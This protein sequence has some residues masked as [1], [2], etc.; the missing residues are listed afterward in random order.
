MAIAIYSVRRMRPLR[1]R[2]SGLAATA[3]ASAGLLR[4]EL[5]RRRLARRYLR[6]SG[7]EV[8]ALHRPLRVS[9]GAKVRYVD[10][11]DTEG[12]RRHYPELEGKKLVEVD[13]ID[14][15]ERLSSQAD[16][17]VD[18]LIANH[19][20]EHTEDP[21]GTLASHL[22]VVRPGGVLYLAVPHRHRTFD[23]DRTATPLEHL[24]RDHREGPAWS[25]SAHYEEWAELVEKAP[26]GTVSERGQALAQQ[27]YSIH[28]HTWDPR[29]FE[30]VLAYARDEAQLPFSI[31]ALTENGHEFIA[32]LR[33]T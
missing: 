10:R 14:D 6:G 27:G 18:F 13:V 31:E 28:F 9:G 4:L 3:R 8:G 23:A 19:F 5:R 2:L 17:S 29:E 30:A 26:A 11:L 33:R 22:R 7:L 1:E 16:A 24:V 21:L 20:I 12:L 32:I 15:G 25:R